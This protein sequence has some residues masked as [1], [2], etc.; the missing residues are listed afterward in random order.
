LNEWNLWMDWMDANGI[1]WCN[2][3]IADK[4]ETCSVLKP[5][6]A[7]SGGWSRKDLK[8]SGT[9]ARDLIREENAR[10]F[11]PDGAR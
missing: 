5:G 4:R 7:A 6:A 3:C 11:P 8:E 1:S 2:W 9:I 10:A